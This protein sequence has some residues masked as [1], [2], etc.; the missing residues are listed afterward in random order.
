MPG[1]GIAV[2]HQLHQLL[3]RRFIAAAAVTTLL[4]HR[5][6]NPWPLR[7]RRAGFA[8]RGF[9]ANIA[10]V[11]AHDSYPFLK[12]NNN[13]QPLRKVAASFG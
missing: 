3:R 13:A 7:F 9:V 2:P 10:V 12:L 5:A 4:R 11:I 6:T 8:G 1:L